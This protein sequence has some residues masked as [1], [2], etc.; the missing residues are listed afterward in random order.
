MRTMAEYYAN[1]PEKE[2]I[3][4]RV[5]FLLMGGNE[6][7]SALKESGFEWD[8]TWSTR[9]YVDPGIWPY[10][11]DY[12]SN[13]VNCVYKDSCSVYS[14]QFYYFYFFKKRN[15]QLKINTLCSGLPNWP[16][17]N[18][19]FSFDLGGADDRLVR[20]QRKPM[21]HARYLYSVRYDYLIY[22]IQ[23]SGIIFF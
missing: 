3:G 7:F 17:P 14:I 1:I 16:M 15:Q 20:C 11:L 21:R 19:F 10:T 9:N 5:P 18:R 6:M 4:S 12:R 8:C 2:I 22:S 13:Q 23:Y